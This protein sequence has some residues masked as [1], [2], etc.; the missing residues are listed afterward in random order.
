[1]DNKFFSITSEGEENFALAMKVAFNVSGHKCTGYS[2][3]KKSNTI[4]LYWADH[5]DSIPFPYQMNN[6]QVTV[7][8]SGWLKTV[9]PIEAE[10]DIDGDVG[11]GF[12]VFCESWGHVDSKWQAF[13]AIQPVWALYGK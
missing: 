8:L 1:M 7:F 12:S 3:D 6:D 4:I 2:V 11:L 10:P 5:K 9:K 13:V